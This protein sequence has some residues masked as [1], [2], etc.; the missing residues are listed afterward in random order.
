M[1]GQASD[2]NRPAC[3]L[4]SDPISFCTDLEISDFRAFSITDDTDIL[5][6]RGIDSPGYVDDAVVLSVEY[7]FE[8]SVLGTG[9]NPFLDRRSINIGKKDDDS[10]IHEAAQR[11]SFIDSLCKSHK[12]ICS[13]NTPFCHRAITRRSLTDLHLGIFA[14]KGLYGQQCFTYDIIRIGIKDDASLLRSFRCI[15]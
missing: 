10:I 7:T 14:G 11:C 2:I 3:S 9:R 8:R 1:S 12:V 5:I 15:S 4:D 6:F 13:S